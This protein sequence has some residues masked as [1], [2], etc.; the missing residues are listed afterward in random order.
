MAK[1]PNQAR[2]ITIESLKEPF[3]RQIADII[4]T[5]TVEVNAMQLTD[6]V[7]KV[8]VTLKD[9]IGSGFDSGKTEGYNI[10][11]AIGQQVMKKIQLE[12]RDK[13][14][15][16]AYKRGYQQCKKDTAILVSHADPEENISK[17]VADLVP[18]SGVQ[19]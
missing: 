9:A 3:A 6:I 11:K 17:I 7:E 10:G 2:D 1:N 14:V 19:A 4:V 13:D 12:I 16:D 18:K 8:E 15:N 5:S